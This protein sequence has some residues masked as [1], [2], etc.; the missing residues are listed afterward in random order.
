MG[1]IETQ[2]LLAR[3]FTDA[4]ARRVFFE[5]PHLAALGFGLSEKEAE[6]IAALDRREVEAF[7]R[8]LLGKRALDARKALPLTAKVLGGDFDRLVIQAIEG[9]PSPQRHRAD[10]AALVELLTSRTM[11]PPWISD[12][13]RY[14]LAF[15][16]AARPGAFFLMRRFAWPIDHIARQ[17][18]A[19]AH[20]EASPRR[21]IALWLRGPQ[22]RLIFRLF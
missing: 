7:S 11:E 8:S 16:A 6:T 9:P 19:G 3:I 13:A 22:G 15:V 4:T 17:L 18:L 20:V 14:E 5:D 1:L 12:L 10:A 21:R 2:A